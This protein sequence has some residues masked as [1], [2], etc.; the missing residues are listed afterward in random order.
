MFLGKNCK[1]GCCNIV[2]HKDVKR[3]AG[4]GKAF[5]CNNGK[6]ELLAVPDDYT[7][8]REE[9]EKCEFKGKKSVPKINFFK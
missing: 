6:V 3:G 9:F 2:C 7:S 8:P 5:V 1:N 4:K